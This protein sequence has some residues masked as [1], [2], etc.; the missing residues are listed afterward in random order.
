MAETPKFQFSDIFRKIWNKY[1]HWLE[2]HPKPTNIATA[3]VLF[4]AGDALS[5]I[6]EHQQKTEPTKFEWDRALRMT[7][8]GV[9]FSVHLLTTGIN[10]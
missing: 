1:N 9:I 4:L 3:G 2:H 7:L 5:Q 6:I 8:F 10:G